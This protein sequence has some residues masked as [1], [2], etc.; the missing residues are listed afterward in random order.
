[1]SSSRSL[2]NPAVLFGLAALTIVSC[3]LL[4]VRS[5]LFARNPDVAAWGVTFDLAI[6]IPLV[7]YLIVVRRGR[8]RAL[9][10]APVVVICMALAALVVPRGQQQFLHQLRLLAMPLDLVTIGLLLR[11]LVTMRRTAQEAPDVLALI[12]RAA[13][14]AFG[15]ERIAA[16]VASEIAILYYALICWRK[17]PAAPEGMRAISV[18]ERSGWGSV[19]ACIVVLIAFES[20]GMHLLVQHWSTTG[21][22]ILTALDLYGMLWVL[23]DYHALRLRPTLISPAAIQLRYGL[24][25]SARIE[26]DNVAAIDPVRDERDWK[27]RGTLKVALLDEPK[28]LIRL[29][30][31]IVVHGLAGLTKTIDSVAILPDDEAAF[32]A[33]VAL[34]R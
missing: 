18:H 29:R 7:Y 34:F 19:A 6:T 8:A 10:L 16:F 5:R 11:R 17:Q 28:V 27:R 14:A 20:L 9:T 25:W 21:A 22:W 32:A 26:W 23:G 12:E 30:Q 3:V 31:P 4:I 13:V 15:N 33:A 24:R 2:R 1:M